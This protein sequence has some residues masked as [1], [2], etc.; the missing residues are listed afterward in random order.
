MKNQQFLYSI[1]LLFCNFNLAQ[2]QLDQW[3]ISP[4]KMDMNLSKPVPN[5]IQPASGIST[6]GSTVRV[7]NGMYDE[8][9][10]LIF[11]V[12][13][14]KVFDYNNNELGSIKSGGTEIIIVPFGN[15]SSC[16]RKF[17][18]FS[19]SGGFTSASSLWQ[20]VLDMNSF[21]L[22]SYL[23]DT[24][25][26]QGYTS[27]E[28]GAIALSNLTSANVRYLYF[29]AGP[30]TINS[31]VGG[32]KKITVNING[33]VTINGR[34]YPTIANLNNNAGAEIFAQELD[35]SPDGRWLAWGSY[36]FA[37]NTTYGTQFRYHLL[38]LDASG[39]YLNNSYK[40]FN[41]PSISGNNNVNSF[42]GVEFLQKSSSTGMSTQ[43]FI[44]AGS[45]GIYSIEIPLVN[46]IPLFTDFTQVVNSNLGFGF[47][48]LE[49]ANNSFMYA[50]MGG[51]F[52]NVGAFD[53]NNISPIILN[54]SSFTLPSPLPQGGF[55]GAS[56]YTLPDQIDGQDYSLITPGF[57]SPVV[58]TDVLEFP[59]IGSNLIQ[60]WAY[61]AIT[62][63]LGTLTEVHVI[64]ELRIKNF[65]TLT[66][67]GMT[68]RFS[69]N[70]KVIIEPGST[71]ILKNSIF[72]SNYNWDPCDY[73]YTWKGIELL[74]TSS[75]SQN[76]LATQGHVEI[77]QNS[78]IEFAE[79]GI[80]VGKLDNKIY[81]GGTIK[82]NN[83]TFMDNKIDIDYLP[84]QN[85]IIVSSGQKNTPNV[86]SFQN[87]IFSS[88]INYPFSAAPIHV[89]LDKCYGFRFAN[90]VFETVSTTLNS[91]LTRGIYAK[92][93]GFIIGAN[94]SFNRLW[95]GIDHISTGSSHFTLIENSNFT[96]DNLAILVRG[97]NNVIIRNND[98][99][100][101]S[102]VSQI[103]NYQYGLMMKNSSGFKI[104]ENR[105]NGSNTSNPSTSTRGILINSSGSSNN[106]IY[107]NSFTDLSYG[108][109]AYGT[110]GD[111]MN[112][113]N[114]GLEYICN[115]NNSNK[116]YDIFVSDGIINNSIPG[117]KAY[118]GSKSITAGNTFTNPAPIAFHHFFNKPSF[119]INYYTNNLLSQ[120]PVLNNNLKIFSPNT[121]LS[122]TCPSLINPSPNFIMTDTEWLNWKNEYYQL[123]NSYLNL[124]YSY[125]QLLDGGNTNSLL[126]QVQQT[127]S[128][129]AIQLRDELLTLSPYVSQD[130]LREVAN[131]W[132]LPQAMLLQ[133]CL[134]NPDA[135]KNTDFLKFLEFGIPNPLS[136]Y[137]I[138]MI[139][140]SW[141]T[142]TF[143]TDMESTLGQIGQK[144]SVISNQIITGLKFRND[145]IQDSIHLND[146]TNY[147]AQINF[148][149]N[150]IGT[151]AGKYELA[152]N[153]ISLHEYVLAQQLIDSLPLY[154]N[155]SESELSDFADFTSYF[156][157]LKSVYEQN[158]TL[159][160]LNPEKIEEL[161]LLA[162]TQ[163]ENIAE[164][165]AQNILCFYYNICAE[166]N[167]DFTTS[168]N[169][170][171]HPKGNKQALDKRLV[172]IVP[173]PAKESAIFIY[174]FHDLKNCSITLKI[175]D[176][177]GKIMDIQNVSSC[178]GTINYNTSELKNGLYFYFFQ[179]QNEDVAHGKF[180]VN[181]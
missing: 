119:Q 125:I 98:F 16:Q 32:I 68:F 141:E 51:M 127:W 129:D 11:Y 157:F 158:M 12:A 178:F 181:K 83:A 126:N 118:Q 4:N 9:G 33:S 63:P 156:N 144:M 13:D 171:M 57:V 44:G 142:E 27:T 47:S 64:K 159:D 7:A 112:S 140:S 60:T 61:G 14:D 107:K 130:V 75:Q 100:I 135:T 172:N 150:R 124:L 161:I 23:I 10:Y 20:T 89:K 38:E 136:S 148:W 109:I 8:L 48:Q 26:Y 165:M 147:S 29:L 39:Q 132:V 123:E 111:Q 116:E 24:I 179:A 151:I 115:L 80:R 6:A 102:N 121:I 138:G 25:K 36:A 28:F 65:S 106:I 66:I 110:N 176:P 1:L 122:N 146:T 72:T 85:F 34:I 173:N 87:T 86:S 22:T 143:R 88:G 62:N 15:N 92:D 95:R 152:N 177:S 17:N 91:S 3:Y 52:N 168:S 18:I 84:Y 105:F 53:P 79:C 117:I 128:N 114:S 133:I 71:L 97:I 37:N 166:D 30:G 45:D 58:T 40:R 163:R 81:S 73:T 77:L 49:M 131:N 55:L 59:A 162:N 78:K 54:S 21:T 70:A 69:P 101:G 170:M 169:R 149:N 137:M 41:I 67:D 90:C 96:S 46:S 154:F 50:S 82:C 153:Y 134:V 2:A 43:L 76:N 35:L 145:M 103:N 42:R 164:T 74:G 180:I 31:S 56:L 120:S 160:E 93:A 139:V 174:D 94:T 5:Q 108:N 167:Y 99:D 104:E 155:L 175:L 113:F 19:T